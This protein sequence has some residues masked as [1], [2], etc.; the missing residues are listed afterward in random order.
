MKAFLETFRVVPGYEGIYEVSDYGVVRSL[1]YLRTGKRRELKPGKSKKG[2]EAVILSR[3][4]VKKRFTV[5][6]LVWEAFNGD[7]PEGLQ[8]DHINGA[9]ND[10]RLAN[11]RVVTTKQNANNPITCERRREATKRR[12]ENMEWREVHREAIKRRSE[13]PKWQE[14]NRRAVRKAKAKPILQIDK[15]SGALVRDWECIHDVEREL[16]IHHANITSC[17]RGKR[18]TAG[19]Y[20][21]E[22]KQQQ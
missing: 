1:N 4:G 11:L 22:F 10:N 20:R 12:F 9:K 13:D 15:D 6:R 5:H 7:I 14:A 16:G 8:I 18:K 2:Y 3:D 17:C 21:W 19:G